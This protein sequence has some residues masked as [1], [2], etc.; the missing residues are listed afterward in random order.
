MVLS[1]KRTA[2]TFR[3]IYLFKFDFLQKLDFEFFAHILQFSV[4]YLHGVLFESPLCS[5]LHPVRFREE[6]SHMTPM[7]RS[8]VIAELGFCN[9]EPVVSQCRKLFTQHVIGS[10]RITSGD[11]R[12]AVFNVIA[13]NVETPQDIDPLLRLYSQTDMVNIIPVLGSLQILCGFRIF[14]TGGQILK[15]GGTGTRPTVENLKQR[16]RLSLAA[17]T[18][19]H[20]IN[21]SKGAGLKPPQPQPSLPLQ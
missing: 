9:Y 13:A 5:F 8:L 21:L 2:C 17:V 10:D 3:K 12:K 4:S 14:S 1:L 15:R 11:V 19:V 20:S 7:L 6:Q 16:K 18:S